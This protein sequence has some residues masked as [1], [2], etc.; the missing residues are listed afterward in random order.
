MTSRLAVRRVP[1]ET[2]KR[3]RAYA[4]HV[5][6]LLATG[7]RIIVGPWL[8]EVGWEVMYW[9]PLLRWT[10]QRWPK[11]QRRAV[12][13]SRGGVAGWYRGIA[14]DYVDLFEA[15]DEA[16]FARRLDQDREQ[17]QAAGKSTQKQGAPTD[18]DAEIA[19]WVSGRFGG[20]RLPMLH[21]STMF[22][23]AAAKKLVSTDTSGFVR[24]PRPRRGPLRGILPKRYVAVRFYKSGMMDDA[25]F[26]A[27]ATEFLAE[28]ANVVLLNPGVSPDP[29]H[30]DFESGAEVVRL[31]AHLTLKTNLAV[32]SIAMAHADAVVGTFGGL[33]FVPPH[34]GVPSVCFW[35][36]T[37]RGE[38][39]NGL[40]PWRD[41]ERA[42]R[43]YNQPGW[44]GFAAARGDMDALAAAV[45][46]VLPR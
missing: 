13:V 26:A 34:Y 36:A 32:Q 4:R 35:S 12:V 25:E 39:G 10:I 18:W 8:A 42:T 3:L 29:R 21:P 1:P 23:N 41:L 30:P 46:R 6:D 2:P 16:T 33:A 11:L 37:H 28:R 45:D 38:P 40:G 24:W 9:I 43:I 19:E 44:G 15:Y 20:G 7:E 14:R 31:D 17:R 27:A 22:G 5:E